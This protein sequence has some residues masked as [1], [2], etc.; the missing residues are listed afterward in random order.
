[1]DLILWVNN[2]DTV[3]RDVDAVRT[4]RIR[5]IKGSFHRAYYGST[6]FLIAP[7]TCLKH[8]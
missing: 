5:E 8:M 4:Y 1:M 2:L 7:S 3:A 6:L